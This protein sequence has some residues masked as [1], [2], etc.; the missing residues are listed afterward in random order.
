MKLKKLCAA[1]LSLL[2]LT[3][4]AE[5]PD[6]DIIVHKDMEKLIDEAQQTGESKAEVA[7]LQKNNRYTADF[8][9]ENLQ[10]KVHADAEVVIPDIDTLSMYRVRQRRFT[11][12]DCDRVREALMGDAPLADCTRIMEIQT[13]GDL[14]KMIAEYRQ[15]LADEEQHL[16]NDPEY[17]AQVEQDGV[18]SLADMQRRIDKL[19][20]EYEAAPDI[21]DYTAYASD[22]K[23]EK[24]AD[25]FLE[26]LY[27]DEQAKIK[28]Q[29]GEYYYSAY[30]DDYIFHL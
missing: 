29:Q 2:M 26:I 28:D 11:Q 20:A 13:K 1:A 14:E 5:N 8:V 19:Q 22:G 25:A 30:F 17:A 10:V 7:E 12:E 18:D 27:N 15:I 23:L 4:C 6:S 21:I 24:N 16:A 9:N 3:G